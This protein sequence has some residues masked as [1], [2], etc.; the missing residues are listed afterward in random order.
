MFGLGKDMK[1]TIGL[2]EAQDIGITVSSFADIGWNKPA[3]Q[4]EHYLGEQDRGE[5]VVLVAYSGESFAGYVTIV[6]QS[7]YPPFAEKGIPEVK[8]LNVLPAFRRHGI[9]SALMDE[10]ER[11]VFERSGIAGI[12]F[13][14]SA[15]YG[16]AQRMYVLRGYVPDG[17]GLFGNGQY[18]REPSTVQVD[19]CVIYLTK[20]RGD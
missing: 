19:D 3:S 14:I 6:W 18:I 12:G 11:R 13:G 9:A 5:R 2:L 8:D 7:D 10:A 17:R 4:Y 1:I 15:D 16:A 20:E